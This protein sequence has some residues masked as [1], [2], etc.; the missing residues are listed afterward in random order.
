M[1]AATGFGSSWHR[2]GYAET[3]TAMINVPANIFRAYD[4]RGV[5]DQTLTTEGV[6]AIGCAFASEAIDRDCRSVVVARDGRLSGRRLIVALTQ[7]LLAGGCDVIDIGQVPTPLL[8]FATHHLNTGT[9]VM[10]TGSHNP[11]DYNGLKMMIGGDTLFGEGI[12][13]LYQR[14]LDGR[15]R[16]GQGCQRQQ[17]VRQ[18]Y[19]Q[20]IVDDVKLRRPLRI[21]VDCGNGVAGELAPQLFKAL[22]CEVVELFTD[23]DGRFPNHHPDPSKPENMQDLIDTVKGQQ[24]D[25][26]LA[27]DGDG[28]R[29]G[30]IDNRGQLIW[31][32]RQM[33]LFAEDVISRHPKARI[34][35]D[36]KCSRRLPEAIERVG[37]IADMS[38][39]GHSFIKS[40]I[41]QTQALLGGEMSGHLFFKERWYGFDDA[42]YAG[43]RLLEILSSQDQSAHDLFARIPNSYNTPEL[44]IAFEEGQHHAFMQRFIQQA[45]IPEATV[46]TIDGLRAD[47]VDGFG[48]VRASNT[49]SVLVIRFEGDTE[50]ALQRIQT[51]F[52]EQ[53][54][55]LEPSLDLPF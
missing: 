54:L 13:A 22:G 45:T 1:H 21:G 23:I 35:Y 51:L 41:K 15:W 40:R 34:I 14:I 50:H 11:P 47:F 17:D 37:G 38:K 33:I 8:Y 39:T 52:R 5:V 48:L 53:M 7:G 27:F 49:T 31:P 46:A 55:A 19:L 36:V 24:L 9:G 26:G 12:T 10:L 6:E 29:L 42:L 43:A 2:V 16:R 30:V 44:N 4:I 25:L 20:R 32:D 3:E 18:A 28:D